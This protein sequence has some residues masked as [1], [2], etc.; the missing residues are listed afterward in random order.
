MISFMFGVLGSVI[1]W[2]VFFIVG[3]V[4]GSISFRYCCPLAYKFLV[5]KE[6]QHS[7]GKCGDAFSASTLFTIHMILWP[8]ISTLFILKIIMGKALL[9]MFRKG[10]LIA[11]T[12][13]P[14]FEIKKKED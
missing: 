13:I 10:I 5:T 6:T 2:V 3:F 9:P 12:I 7:G 1:F 14:E 11:S 8:I 4:C